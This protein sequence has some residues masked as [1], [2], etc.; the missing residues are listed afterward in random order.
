LELRKSKDILLY[1][2]P[3]LVASMVGNSG[4]VSADLT[5][6]GQILLNGEIWSGEY[7]GDSNKRISVGTEVEVVSVD[8]I[9]LKVKLLGTETGTDDVS[10]ND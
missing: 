2:S 9:N 1:Q 6:S 5:P 8:G 10:S 7:D 4:V 3:T